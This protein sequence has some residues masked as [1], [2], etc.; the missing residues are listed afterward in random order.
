VA[1]YY[2]KSTNQ[3]VEAEKV[4]EI[5]ETFTN[6]DGVVTVTQGNY[7]VIGDDGKKVGMAAVDF[8]LYYSKKKSKSTTD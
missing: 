2:H 3:K 8:E 5:H 7:I 1:I 4:K 6:E